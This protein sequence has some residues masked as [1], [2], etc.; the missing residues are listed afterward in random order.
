M[1]EYEQYLLD[2]R[3]C[4]NGAC[5]FIPNMCNALKN[6]HPEYSNKGIRNQITKDCVNAGLAQSTITHSIPEDFKDPIKVAT[7]KKRAEK[8]KIVLSKTTS[9]AAVSQTENDPESQ[10]K[11]NL[12]SLEIPKHTEDYTN[13]E[14]NDTNEWQLGNKD[15]DVEILKSE[16]NR[17]TEE[18]R[19]KDIL[20]QRLQEEKS[21]LGEVVRKN[22][23]TPATNYR[24]GPPK[25]FEFPE[26]DE[27]NTF[28]WKEITF[29]QLE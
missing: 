29:D 27:S 17:Q 11:P 9:G 6:E 18:N 10:Y 12:G 8:K 15:E 19:L 14:I 3:A 23:F 13:K 21:Q 2:L 24:P 22:S 20:I 28:V 1:T 26:P 4:V 25:K 5:T 16:L 7:G